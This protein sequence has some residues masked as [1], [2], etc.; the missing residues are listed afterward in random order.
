M[1]ERYCVPQSGPSVELRGVVVLPENFQQVFVAN[2]GGVELYFYRFSV[3]G[4]IGANI[5]VGGA[6][7]VSAGV[8]YSRSEHTWHLPEGGF[9]SPETSGCKCGF[10]HR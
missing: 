7:G 1:A 8:A 4:P 9:H 6:V 2:L 3:A 10:L 5:F